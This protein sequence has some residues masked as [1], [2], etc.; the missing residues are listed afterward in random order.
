VVGLAGLGSLLDGGRPAV[1]WIAAGV[2]LAFVILGGFS[3]GFYLIPGLLLFIA[4]AALR[5][6][7]HV[8][9]IL[10]NLGLLLG[11]AVLQIAFMSLMIAVL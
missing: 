1:T 10:R 9:G 7:E 2:L 3:I 8:T 5:Q 11:A 6:S 4:G